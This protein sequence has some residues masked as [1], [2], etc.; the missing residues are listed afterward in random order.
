MNEDR[1]ELLPPGTAL[2]WGHTAAPRRGP[3]PAYSVEQIVEAA[4][5]Q[6]DAEGFEALSM[7]AIAK[8][9][10]ITANAL[11]RYLRSKEEL[12]VLAA[13]AGWGL[14]PEPLTGDWRTA[15]TTWAHALLERCRLHPWLLEVPVR[16]G[17]TTPNL[18]RWLEV[19]LEAM[20]DSGLSD[21]DALGCATLVD[22]W[23]R[24]TAALLRDIRASASDEQPAALNEFLQP[25]LRERG[26]PRVAAVLGGDYGE[27]GMQDTDVEFGLDRI[28]DGIEALVAQR[29]A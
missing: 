5:A 21:R 18:L 11:Y 26:Y 2:A 27:D 22:G 25:R 24:S 29:R 3:K 20:A 19:F 8:R 7:P 28:L 16:G 10:G 1:M 14:P 9:L 6:A 23:A 12:L 17:P 13:E 4:V 15:V